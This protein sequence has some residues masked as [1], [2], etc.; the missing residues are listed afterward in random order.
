MI[1]HLV[2]TKE[3]EDLFCCVR[4][5]KCDHVKCMGWRW[6]YVT[7]SDEERLGYCGLAGKPM[8]H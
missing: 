6:S 2:T 8:S 3:A 4:L 5:E 7:S 1:D